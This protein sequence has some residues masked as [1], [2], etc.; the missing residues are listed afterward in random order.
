[1]VVV[2]VV[3]ITH[4]DNSKRTTL[5]FWVSGPEGHEKH[6]TSLPGEP[7][8]AIEATAPTAE[9][10]AAPT[11][12]VFTEALADVVFISSLESSLSTLSFDSNDNTAKHQETLDSYMR[13]IDGLLYR[14]EI[15]TVEIASV[16][17][18]SPILGR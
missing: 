15:T 17:S 10:D 8:L 1:V 2:V 9:T 18:K 7:L 11:V 5:E 4:H 12:S 16:I 6:Y 13:A 3:T 14:H